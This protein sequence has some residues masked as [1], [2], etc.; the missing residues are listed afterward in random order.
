MSASE[1][2]RSHR[3]PLIRV[4]RALVVGFAG[5]ALA[6]YLFDPV[7]GKKRRVL[8]RDQARHKARM[9]AERARV[10]FHDAAHRTQGALAEARAAFRPE[11]VLDDVLV[12]RVRAAMGRVVSHPHWI[13]TAAHDGRVVLRGMIPADEIGRLL[14]CVEAVRGARTIENH[15]R[16][17]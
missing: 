13:D 4:L 14:A 9:A 7:R 3:H 10:S 12:E 1:G 2:S 8:L 11:V 16:L 6:M 17:R 5:G 15:L